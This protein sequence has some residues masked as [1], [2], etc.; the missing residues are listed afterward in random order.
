V[1]LLHQQRTKPLFEPVNHLQRRMHRQITGKKCEKLAPR[2]LRAIVELQG[3]G[4]GDSF[5]I[6]LAQ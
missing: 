5:A 4:Y 6:A 1:V 3:A 2:L